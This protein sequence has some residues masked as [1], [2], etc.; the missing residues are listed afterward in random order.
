MRHR[1]YQTPFTC[2]NI[3]TPSINT[4]IRL[5]LWL[6]NTNKENYTTDQRDRSVGNKA[7]MK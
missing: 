7:K 4:N 1:T 5:E 2:L 6:N 3:Y